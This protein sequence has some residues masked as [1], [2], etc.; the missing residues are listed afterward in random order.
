MTTI[1]FQG[2]SITDCGRREEKDNLGFGYA[3]MVTQALTKKYPQKSFTFYN[4][5]ISGNRTFDLKGRWRSECLDL[6]PDVM[7]I[8]IGINDVWRKVDSNDYTSDEAF[9]DNLEYL[10]KSVKEKGVK[11]IVL[12]PF[13]IP[14]GAG[15]RE[16]MREELDAKLRVLR[17]VA[18]KYA[19]RY[20]ALDG[21]FYEEAI[22][23]NKPSEY[24]SGDGVHPSEDGHK[25]I[26]GKV[27]EAIE[28]FV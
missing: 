22:N 16:G 25:F 13:L 20:I 6:K 26:A 5:G 7:T 10:L 17:P 24:Y 23:N 1:L 12:E 9:A 8:L 19:D 14:C 18:S 11:I 27:I 28:K 4:R 2:D 15:V 21:L 3:R